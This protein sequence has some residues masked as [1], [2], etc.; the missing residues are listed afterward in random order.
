MSAPSFLCGIL[1]AWTIAQVGLSA[2]F[3]LVYLVGRRDLAYLL[4]ALLCFALAFVT[5]GVAVSYGTSSLQVNIEASYL[6]RGADIAAAAVN[7]HFATRYAGMR[8]SPRWIWAIYAVAVPYEL[9]V[10]T[11][12]WW[13]PHSF[14]PV[15]SHVF[16]YGLVHYAAVANPVAMTFY[17]VGVAEV[18]VAMLCFFLAYRAGRRDAL[19]PLAGGVIVALCVVNDILM[20]TKGV[21]SVYL[22]PH[23]FL[24]YA[25]AV[26]SS[27]LVRHRRLEKAA[28]KLRR[29]LRNSHAE[30]RQVQNEL[31]VKSQLAVV[32]ELAAS[33]AHEVRNPLAVIV[34]AVAG[35]RRKNLREPDRDML[36]DIV[37]EEAARLNRLVTDL[38]RFAR[39]VNVNY[40]PVSL[41]EL[42]NRAQESVDSQYIVEINMEDDPALWTVPADPGLM[43]LVFDNVIENALQAM[44]ERGRLTISAEHETSN[45]TDFVRIDVRDTGEGMDA[46]ALRR[47]V[48]PF[49]T[50]RPSG[51][52]LGLPIVE[53]IVSAHGGSVRIQSE[54]GAGTTVSLLLPLGQQTP[55]PG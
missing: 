10:W 33:I 8:R 50:T 20:L 53:R 42:A 15:V 44:P 21:H 4:F 6:A 3:G 40:S 26:A 27:L 52:G 51:T 14:R 28:S 38:L 18:L 35:L 29:K 22:I 17:V 34:N 1:V 36:L 12:H 23:G 55:R 5:F 43:R 25:F 2:Y 9:L 7:L 16:G 45:G 48:D 19:L 39:P 46:D 54:P 13:R 30:L 47:A 41:R 37:D 24:L 32:G 31:A 11:G 49:F